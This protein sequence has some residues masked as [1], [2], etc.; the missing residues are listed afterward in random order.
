MAGKYFSVEIKPIITASTQANQFTNKDVLFDWTSFQVPKG[1]NKLLSVNA[2]FRSANGA[3]QTARDVDL[4]FAKTI[5]GTAPTTLGTVNATVVA[6]PIV[7]NHII[8]MAHLDSG[9]D[10]GQAGFDFGTV[11]QT[12]SGAAASLVPNMVLQG[13]PDSGD[14]VGFD[15]LYIGGIAGGSFDFGTTVITRGSAS[16]EATSVPTDAGSDDDPNAENVFAIGDTI[17]SAD[18]DVLG[19]LTSIADFATNN[20]ALGFSAGI[21]EAVADNKELFNPNPMKIILSFER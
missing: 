2:T 15:T 4:V 9:G 11:A 16:A 20:Q 7:F 12:G 21:A 19:T 18:G 5:D 3:T 14:N 13:E 17:H 8:G 6:A 1:A 10:Y